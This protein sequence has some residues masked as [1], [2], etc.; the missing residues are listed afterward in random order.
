[1]KLIRLVCISLDRHLDLVSGMPSVSVSFVIFGQMVFLKSVV[2][3]RMETKVQIH[4]HL[5][6]QISFSCFAYFDSLFDRNTD[7]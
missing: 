7:F 1:M 6:I 3:L 2:L 4:V 5:A